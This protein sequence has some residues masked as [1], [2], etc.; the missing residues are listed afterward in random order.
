MSSSFDALCDD[1][2]QEKG[3]PGDLWIRWARQVMWRSW[4]Q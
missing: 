2:Y 4:A 3:R 1:D